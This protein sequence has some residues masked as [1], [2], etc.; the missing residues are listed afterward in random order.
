M[1]KRLPFLSL[2]SLLSLQSLVSFPAAAQSTPQ[3]EANKA[4]VRRYLAEV[5]S[6]GRL[7][8][9]E[10]FV[11]ADFADR[12]PGAPEERGPK[13]IREAQE[14]ARAV[15]PEV[16]YTVEDLIAEGDRVVARYVV[17]ARTKKTDDAPAT[18]VE[19][20]GITVFRVSGGKIREAWIVNDQIELFTQLG[21][22]LEPPKKDVAAP[23]PPPPAEPAPA[24]PPASGV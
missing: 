17:R 10:E 9:L 24:N 20:M 6:A 21:Y 7:D 3:Q 4:L 5:L 12:T 11:A 2:L 22:T 23:E 13:I 14:R 19:V 15:F 8:R 1:F 18:N 16:E